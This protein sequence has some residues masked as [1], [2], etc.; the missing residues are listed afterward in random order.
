MLLLLNQI[1]EFCDFEFEIPITSKI[2]VHKSQKFLG[3]E[4]SESLLRENKIV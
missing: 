4:L 3:A 1:F 2:F